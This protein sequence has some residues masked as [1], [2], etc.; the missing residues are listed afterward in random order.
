MGAGNISSK[1]SSTFQNMKKNGTDIELYAIAARDLERAQAFAAEWGYT[2]AYGSYADMLSDPDVDFVYI[3]TPHSHHAEHMKLCLQ[4]GKPILCEK[5]FT[6]N[7]RQAEEV[8]A[9]AREKGILVAEAIWTRYMPSRKMINDLVASGVIGQPKLL[10]ANLGYRIAHIERIARPELAGGALLDVGVYPIN[11]ASM[12]FGNDIVR[13][14]SS[15]A[16]TELGVDHTESISLYYRNGQVAHLMATSLAQT[17]RKGV[18]Y[19]DK[20]FLAVDNINNPQVLEVYENG[21]LTD[22]I[23]V[24]QQ[25]DG[26]EYQVESFLHALKEGWLECPEMPHAETITIMRQMDALRAQ[27]N[28]RYPFD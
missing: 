6:G 24:P 15:V 4:Y 12:V 9:L 26:Y 3:G 22:T 11:F 20:G 13:M 28:M 23:H 7:A 21:K 1:L 16:M 8:L 25:I 18:V 5:S 17:D 10:T 2:K 14:E 19:G 27:W